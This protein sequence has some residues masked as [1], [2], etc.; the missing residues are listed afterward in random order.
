MNIG[1]TLFTA[2]QLQF[3]A[4]IEVFLA[5]ARGDMHDAG[6]FRFGHLI[7]LDDAVRRNGFRRAVQHVERT[8]IRQPDKLLPDYFLH[9][10]ERAVVVEMGLNRHQPG[11]LFQEDIPASPRIPM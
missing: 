11:E 1:G 7:P 6:S 5:A 8:V 10:L 4:Q 3:F 9:N 2:R